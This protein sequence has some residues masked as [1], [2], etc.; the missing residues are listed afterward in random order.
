ML[1]TLPRLKGLLGPPVDAMGDEMLM[2]H[3]A[4][5]SSAIEKRCKRRFKKQRYTERISG[6]RKSKYINLQNYPVHDIELPSDWNYEVLEDGRVYRAEGWPVGDH[7]ITVSYTGGY[8]LP[9]DASEE[10]PRTLPESLELA[11]LLLCQIMIRTPGIRTER[12]GDL[13]VTYEDSG[14][15]GCLPRPVESLITGY[16]GRWV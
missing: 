3:I 14:F 6:D 5:A 7:N 1:T 15:D 13:S 16:V 4:S 9:G 11:C 2:L 10:Q 8:V 12:V